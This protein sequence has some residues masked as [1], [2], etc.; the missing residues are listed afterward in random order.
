MRINTAPALLAAGLTSPSAGRNIAGKRYGVY[1]RYSTTDLQVGRRLS[2]RE[3]VAAI[4]S[5]LRGKRV[6]DVERIHVTGPS[7][8]ATAADWHRYGFTPEGVHEWLEV[9]VYEASVAAEMR[10]LDV[11]P[12]GPV[13][14]EEVAGMRLGVAVSEGDISTPEVARMYQRA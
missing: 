10:G 7:A 14:S 8:K 3:S 13:W 1:D 2:P 12:A 11:R 4:A 5:V 9:G 6:E